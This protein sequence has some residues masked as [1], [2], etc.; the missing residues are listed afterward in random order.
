[1][2]NIVS[3]TRAKEICSLIVRATLYLIRHGKASTQHW[4]A[5]VEG[6]RTDPDSGYDA[7]DP[8]GHEQAHLLGAALARRGVRFDRLW[9]GPMTR[10]RQT[11]SNMRAAAE[12]RGVHWPAEQE[13]EDLREV[14]LDALVRAELPRLVSADDQVRALWEQSSS[15]GGVR[16]DHP[17]RPF[18]RI[19][20]HLTREWQRGRL[21]SPCIETWEAF[22]ARVTSALTSIL[23][24]CRDGQC[25]A[26]VTSM[27]VVAGMLEAVSSLPTSGDELLPFRWLHTASISRLRWDGLSLTLEQANDVEHLRHRADLLTLL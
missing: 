26:V 12:A 5:G 11:L 25:V 24:S 4:I 22:R 20:V 19:V 10:H 7:L 17:D 1:M 2:T 13:R 16:T 27:G 6:R 3:N 8:I 9:C 14:A 21:P 23:E 18:L 15:E